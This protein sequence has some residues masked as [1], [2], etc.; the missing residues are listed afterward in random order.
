MSSRRDQATRS[1]VPAPAP[2]PRRT[3]LALVLAAVVTLVIAPAA[4]ASTVSVDGNTLL[5]VAAPGEVNAVSVSE[6]VPGGTDS[7]ADYRV[8]DLPAGATPGPGCTLEPSRYPQEAV[9]ICPATGVQRVEVRLG[10]GDDAVEQFFLGVPIEVRGE[11]G[12]DRINLVAR[13]G[14]LDGGEGDDELYGADV[15]RGGPGNDRLTGFRLLDGGDGDDVLR[16]TDGELPGR[17]DAGA[18]NDTLDAGDGKADVLVCGAGEDVVLSA[19]AADRPDSTCEK[20]DG[21]A[22]PPDL[23]PRIT[24]FELPGLRSR[25]GKDG[26]LAVWM[27][28]SVPQCAV[29]VQIRAVGEYAT[30]RFVRFAPGSATIRGLVV[31]TKATLVRLALNPRLRRALRRTQDGDLLAAKITASGPGGRSSMLTDGFS[32]RRESPCDEGGSAS[33]RPRPRPRPR[34]SPARSVGARVP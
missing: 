16:K 30:N 7:V 28:C 23:T 12:N 34:T 21:V 13:G 10:D 26:R 27:R 25:P 29:T 32:C 6:R 33:A 15:T 17:L 24:I 11:G 3:A 4:T 14:L 8:T 31:G 5:V 1:T 19:D 18:G 22:A 9:S 20:G 2:E